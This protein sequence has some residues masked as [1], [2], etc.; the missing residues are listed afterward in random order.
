MT[1]LQIAG[2]L[3][4]ICVACILNLRGIMY[5]SPVATV[6]HMKQ[7]FQW[8]SNNSSLPSIFL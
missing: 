8:V 1:F 6:P 5:I 2:V 7:A 4:D 3:D